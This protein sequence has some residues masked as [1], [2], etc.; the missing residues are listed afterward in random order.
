MSYLFKFAKSFRILIN[1]SLHMEYKNNIVD[2]IMFFI[3]NCDSKSICNHS[4]I[5][6]K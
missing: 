2:M 6:I 4:Y 3:L 5:F 1:K